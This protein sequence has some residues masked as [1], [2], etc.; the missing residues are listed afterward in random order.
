[1]ETRF[2]LEE[3]YQSRSANLNVTQSSNC[4]S[5][6]QGNHTA[7]KAGKSVAMGE[8]ELTG[9]GTFEKQHTGDGGSL[10]IMKGAII[11]R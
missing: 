1:M 8:G 4:S 3:E 11:E 9:I 2:S 10:L 6:L 5:W 7:E